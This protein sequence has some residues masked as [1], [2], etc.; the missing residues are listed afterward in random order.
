MS[1]SPLPS[2]EEGYKFLFSG[3]VCWSSVH[4]ESGLAPDHQK[5]LAVRE[6]L[7]GARDITVTRQPDDHVAVQHD[8]DVALRTSLSD[9]SGQVRASA[10]DIALTISDD[11]AES[12]RKR[13][14]LRKREQVWEHEQAF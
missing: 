7:T 8:L 6:V 9:Q 12:L 11:D 4:T 2:A 1:N 10:I 5:D 13:F 14:E 3:T